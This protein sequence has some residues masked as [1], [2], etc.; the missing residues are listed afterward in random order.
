MFHRI[1]FEESDNTL[2]YFRTDVD[3][4]RYQLNNNMNPDDMYDGELCEIRPQSLHKK[5]WNQY[6]GVQSKNHR[7]K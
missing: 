2:W 1:C 3:F 5:I 6:Y 4:N 7:K